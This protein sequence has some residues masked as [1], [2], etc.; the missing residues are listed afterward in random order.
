MVR[1]SDHYRDTWRS[2]RIVRT[3]C[4]V[5]GQRRI[6]NGLDRWHVYSGPSSRLSP[7]A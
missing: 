6:R 7:A 5:R 2:N 4:L 1:G 3:L